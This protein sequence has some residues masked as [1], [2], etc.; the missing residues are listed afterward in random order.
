MVTKKRSFFAQRKLA[1]ISWVGFI[2]TTVYLAWKTQE[3]TTRENM[4]ISLLMCLVFLTLATF[5]TSAQHPYS[6]IGN[7]PAIGRG[8][9]MTLCCTLIFI[10]C[11]KYE[12]ARDVISIIERKPTAA[13]L[14]S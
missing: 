11:N 8:L 10:L 2:G 5:N 3:R 9:G 14:K 6:T 4:Q 13:E 1:T 12:D 7:L